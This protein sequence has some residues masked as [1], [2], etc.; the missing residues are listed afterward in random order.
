MVSTTHRSRAPVLRSRRSWPAR[1]S[2]LSKVRPLKIALV[3]GEKDHGFGEH[4]YPRWQQVWSRLLSV[5]SA[6]EV[7]TAWEWPSPVQWESA[8]VLIFFK[9][10]NWTPPRVAEL[11]RF[12]A[13]GGGA[14]FIHW[15]CEAGDH[16]PALAELT[17]LA[18]NS[19]LTKYRHGII[20]LSFDGKA[21]HPITRGFEQ[22]SFHDESYWALVGDHDRLASRSPPPPRPAA[23]T[24]CSGCAAAKAVE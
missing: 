2:P 13:R 12:I 10:G 24:P 4:D 19:R 6:T 3:A 23:P 15:A 8:D 22:T 16:A 14:V 9:R 1:R 21:V 11:E 5:A 20:D 17:G 7:S 18:S